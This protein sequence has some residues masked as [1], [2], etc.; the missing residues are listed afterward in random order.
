M[1]Q[2]MPF[3]VVVFCVLI[4]G[5]GVVVEGGTFTVS[6]WMSDARVAVQV[7]LGL[8]PYL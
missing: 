5:F 4:F 7:R 6:P 2:Q 1:K 8:Y 3:F